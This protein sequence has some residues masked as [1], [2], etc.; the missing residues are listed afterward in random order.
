MIFE[1]TCTD[2]VPICNKKTHE[3]V[4]VLSLTAIK[5]KQQNTENKQQIQSRLLV[6]QSQ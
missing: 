2:M 6:P 1:N 3:N 5:P 4:W